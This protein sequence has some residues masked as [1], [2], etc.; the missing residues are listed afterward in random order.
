MIAA[1]L[2]DEVTVMTYS[3]F[4]RRVAENGSGGTDHGTA[5]PHFVLGGRVR[6]GLHGRQPRLDDLENGDL[7][8]AVDFRSL[9]GAVARDWW[10][11]DHAPVTGGRIAPLS[12]L[13]I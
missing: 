9:Y 7:R 4:G 3:E 10:G 13:L 11:L 8:F 5:A 1:G 12:G 2:W 6:G